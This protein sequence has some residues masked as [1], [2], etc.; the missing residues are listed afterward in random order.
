MDG[1][2][3]PINHVPVTFYIYLAVALFLLCFPRGWMRFGKR[4]SPK[5]PRK[6]NQTKVERDPYDR[7]PKPLQEAAK[8]RN[9]V[10]FFRAAASGYAVMLVAQQWTADPEAAPT[11][12]VLATVAGIWCLGTM[13]QMVRI[14]GRLGLYAP[15]F[16]LQGLGVGVM[17]SV[18]G[19]IA[20]FGSWALSPVLP[21]IGALLFVQGAITLCLSLMIRDAQP[22]TGIVLAGVIWMPVLV[23]VLLKKR[24]T[25]SFDKKFKVVPRDGGN[26]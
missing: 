14:E 1:L 11:G 23:S 16:F 7:S 12:W 2:S 24:L 18:I 21:G 22:I 6:V 19:F 3:V 10:D 17:G 8:S 25:G 15:V 4:V 13:V 26:D 5:P 20:M 9:W